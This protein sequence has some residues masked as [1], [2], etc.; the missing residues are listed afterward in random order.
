MKWAVREMESRYKLMS[1]VGVRAT[2]KA[3]THGLTTRCKS[4][5]EITRPVQGGHDRDAREPPLRRSAD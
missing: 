4:K 2:S 3:L 1:A 5:M